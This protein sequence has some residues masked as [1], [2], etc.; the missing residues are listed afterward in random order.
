MSFIVFLFFFRR[1]Y[2]YIRFNVQIWN[3]Y[4]HCKNW[5]TGVFSKAI[6]I[7]LF[8]SIVT[9]IELIH[10]LYW[11]RNFLIPFQLLKYFLLSL[12]YKSNNLAEHAILK[13]KFEILLN[14]SRLGLYINYY[15]INTNSDYLTR[16]LINCYE[17][18]WI[19]N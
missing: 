12:Y 17:D 8:Y 5:C 9:H 2:H 19:T 14:A 7:I 1:R 6:I 4:L 13:R 18:I 15:Q 10:Q 16:Y 11:Q 3:R